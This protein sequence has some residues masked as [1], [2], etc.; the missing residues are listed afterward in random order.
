M[1]QLRWLFIFLI[2]FTMTSCSN[3]PVYR[4]RFT[5]MELDKS[6]VK[7]YQVAQP[8]MTSPTYSIL[9]GDQKE[10]VWVLYTA[11][12]LQTIGFYE[13]DVDGLLKAEQAGLEKI[14]Q[15]NKEQ[16]NKK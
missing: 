5:Q 4:D 7:K 15:L 9:D 8:P 3:T 14:K 6:L 10:T 12:L 1:N 13:A 2:A 11:D 16:E